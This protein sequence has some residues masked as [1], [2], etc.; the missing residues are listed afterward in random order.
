MINREIIRGLLIWMVV[1]LEGK[2]LGIFLHDVASLSGCFGCVAWLG[3][4]MGVTRDLKMLLRRNMAD[5]LLVCSVKLSIKHFILKS[6]FVRSWRKRHTR[7][8]PKY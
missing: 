1:Q 5:L 3:L 7:P 4:V 8:R 2:S 6:L